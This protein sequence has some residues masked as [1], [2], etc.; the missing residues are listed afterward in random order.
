[1]RKKSDKLHEISDNVK[2]NITDKTVS[3]V[4]TSNY[5]P[6]AMSVIISRAIPEIDGFKPAHRKLLYTM[7]HMGLLSSGRTKSA[8]VVGQTMKLNPHGDASIYE[9]M[10]RLAK[11]NESLLYPFVDSKGNFGKHYSRDMSYAASRYTEVKLSPICAEFFSELDKD[12]VDFVDNYDGTM[13]EPSLLPV[14][15]PSILVNPTMGIAVS[16]ASNIC[17]FN[18]EEICNATITRIKKPKESLLGIIKGPDFPTG[19]DVVYTE[20]T[21]KE[22]IDTGRGAIRVRGKYRNDS[23]NN[24]IEIYEI[25]YSTTVE[26]IIEAIIG[27]VKKGTIKTINNVRDETDLNGLRIAIEYKK[28]TN[29]DELMSIIYKYTPLEDTFSCNF[30]ILIDGTP[31]VMGVSEILDNWLNWRRKCITR[32]LIYDKE[33]KSKRKHLLEGLAK[34]LLNINKAVKIVKDTADDS[35]VVPNLMKAFKIDEEQGEFVANIKLRNFNQDYILNKTNDISILEKEINNIDSILNSKTKL[36]NLIVKQLG[37]IS[38]KYGQPRK[39][40]IID[41]KDIHDVEVTKITE[42]T[43]SANTNIVITKCGYI[44]KIQKVSDINT[45]KLKDGDEV[46]STFFNIPSSYVFLFFTSGHS[47]YRLKAADLKEVKNSD[48]GDYIP[49]LVGFLQDEELIG[50]IISNETSTTE[51]AVLG[52]E[53]GKMVKIPMNSYYTKTNRKKLINSI[54]DASPLVFIDKIEKDKNYK[55]ITDNG[56][57]GFIVN[58]KLI[59]LKVSKNSGGVQVIKLPKNQTAQYDIA[60]KDEKSNIKSIPASP[61]P[62]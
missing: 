23:K 48:L 5:M 61:K 49:S 8:N 52:F 35:L 41:E 33:T 15:F 19:G 31:K 45:I 2:E 60:N 50:T 37:E 32:T 17:S 39:T 6:Y 28:G 51:Y 53:N 44:R 18:L 21:M 9:T 58:S 43:V 56:S 12:A 62:F 16:M 29:I 36:D 14:S 27:L 20:E 13:K 7:Y 25:P 11:N 46:L 3:D 34:I 4:L 40:G 22:V 1:M 59:P 38:K 42:P 57:K 47:I 24:L 10:V 30:N 26:A 54:S 55:V